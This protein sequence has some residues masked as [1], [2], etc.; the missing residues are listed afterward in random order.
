VEA[1]D[2][3][4]EYRLEGLEVEVVDIRAPVVR[5][6]SGLIVTVGPLQ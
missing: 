2:V 3:V 4:G 6:L 1:M 5:K